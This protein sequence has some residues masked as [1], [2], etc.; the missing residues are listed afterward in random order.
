MFSKQKQKPGIGSWRDGLVIIALSVPKALTKTQ[1]I[2]LRSA[3]LSVRN[4]ASTSP[5]K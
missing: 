3:R 1:R 4:V 2:S 5:T